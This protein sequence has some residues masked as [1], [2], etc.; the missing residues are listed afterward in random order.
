M[1]QS[2]DF[3]RDYDSKS[4][5]GGGGRCNV[6]VTYIGTQGRFRAVLTLQ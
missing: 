4:E 5:G 6:C 3:L 1:G 2:F